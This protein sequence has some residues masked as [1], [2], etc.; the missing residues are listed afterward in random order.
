MSLGARVD[1]ADLQT[2]TV[3]VWCRSAPTRTHA[4]EPLH[5]SFHLHAEDNR[6]RFAV[7]LK[8]GD[9][10]RH[11]EIA[12]GSTTQVEFSLSGCRR[13]WIFARAAADLDGLAFLACST[14]GATC[15]LGCAYLIYPACGKPRHLCR[16][17]PDAGR[18]RHRPRRDLRFAA[19]IPVGDATRLIA[20]KA[21]ARTGELLVRQ[22]EAQSR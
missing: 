10:L 3:S 9:E 22:L 6:T 4:G 13:G 21:N 5:L 18:W 2:W 12:A 1:A 17:T 16:A 19:R 15:A 8:L 20:W 7:S 11:V 14:P